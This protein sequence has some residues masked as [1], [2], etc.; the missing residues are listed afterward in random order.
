MS[1]TEERAAIIR[2][3]DTAEYNGER[4][5]WV[6]TTR[7]NVKDL[8]SAFDFD[9][10]ADDVCLNFRDRIERGEHVA[11]VREPVAAKIGAGIVAATPFARSCN[12]HEDCV[13]A[14]AA[15]VAAGK[16]PYVICCHDEDCEDCFG[17]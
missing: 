6:V 11:S 13:A 14:K 8:N 5:D 15:A 1:A 4:K 9:S 7:D 16:N 12:R 3:L 17:S 2:F 10:A